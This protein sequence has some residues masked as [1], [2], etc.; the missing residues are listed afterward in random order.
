[1]KTV[2][3]VRKMELRDQR[4]IYQ[5]KELFCSKGFFNKALKKNCKRIALKSKYH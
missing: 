1:M 3:T 5:E 2:I 4:G